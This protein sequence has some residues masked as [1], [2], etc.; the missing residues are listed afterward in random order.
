MVGLFLIIERK[1]TN[2]AKDKVAKKAPKAKKAAKEAPKGD[3]VGS[4]IDTTKYADRYKQNDTKTASGRKGIDVGDRIAKALRGLDVKAVVKAVKDN[5]GTVNPNWEK[6]N[7][8]LAR[9]AAGNVLR[10]LVRKGTTVEV[11]GTK[12]ASL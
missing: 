1:V 8:G 3:A 7:P 11:E 6:L 10:G 2:M 4:V 9:M 5:G 12:I